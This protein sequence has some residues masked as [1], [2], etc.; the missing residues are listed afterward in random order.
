MDMTLRDDRKALQLDCGNDRTALSIGGKAY[1]F[2]LGGS[3]D[4]LLPLSCHEPVE[5]PCPEEWRPPGVTFECAF[6]EAGPPA[7]ASLQITIGLD[8]ILTIKNPQKKP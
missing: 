3:L 2:H 4:H 5:S 6:I 7:P 8:N 1:G